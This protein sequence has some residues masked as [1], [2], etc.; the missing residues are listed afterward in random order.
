MMTMIVPTPRA[1]QNKCKKDIYQGFSKKLT[2]GLVV[3]PTGGGKTMIASSIAYDYIKKLGKRVLFVVH[4][5]TLIDQTVEAMAN[6]GIVPGVV[7]GN[8]REDRSRLMQIASFQTLNPKESENTKR[9]L[10]RLLE[11]FTPDLI[12]FDECHVLNFSSV[13]LELVPKLRDFEEGYCDRWQIIGLTATPY[14]LRED[15]SLGD[16]YQFMTCAPMPREL[17]EQGVLVPIVYYDVPNAGGGRIGVR[18]PYIVE[19]WLKKG[20]NSK[21]ISF[22]PSVAFAK[23]LSEAFERIGVKSAVVHSG[24][25]YKKRKE[26][27]EDFKSDDPGSCLVL[28][29]CMALTEGFNATN[30][31]CGIF[32]RDTNSKA[33]AVQM[34]GRIVRSHTYPDGTQKTDAIALDCVG[35]YGVSVPYFE[36]IQITEASLH[37]GDLRNPGEKPR[38]KCPEKYG[39]CGAHVPIGTKTCPYCEFVFTIQKQPSIDPGG[40]LQQVVRSDQDKIVFFRKWLR[41]AFD[42]DKSPDWASRKFYQ[43]FKAQPLEGWK[44]NAIY[45][46]PTPEQRE[47]V[48]AYFRRHSFLNNDPNHWESRQL[49]LELGYDGDRTIEDFDP[50]DLDDYDLKPEENS[51]VAY[52]ATELMEAI[53]AMRD[54]GAALSVER[55]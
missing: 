8:Y 28:C 17:I 53:Q 3:A 4:R 18:I 29:S 37:E 36:D 48:R 42:R 24:T 30:A 20:Q 41:I 6:W 47:R 23:S 46:N 33:L 51:V 16:I 2:R 39:G 11:W 38:K 21:T 45:S 14:R 32:A 25:G 12:I 52:S 13:A 54:E 1:Y 31:R 35:L 50:R 44:L 43:R 49:S 7:A 15:E 55:G 19:N 40:D 26:I 34:I 27:Y 9:D 10:S 22:C 5:N